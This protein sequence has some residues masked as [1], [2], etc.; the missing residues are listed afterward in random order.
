MLDQ[1]LELI[2]HAGDKVRTVRFRH[3]YWPRKSVD[4]SI[5][6]Y[7]SRLLILREEVDKIL[8]VISLARNFDS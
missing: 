7:N 4:D 5:T 3:K 8:H 2:I 1:D 6:H